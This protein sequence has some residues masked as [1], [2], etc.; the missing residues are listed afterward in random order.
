M[1][2]ACSMHGRDEKCVQNFYQKTRKEET[3]WK[4]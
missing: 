4:T 1:G 3:M 2:G